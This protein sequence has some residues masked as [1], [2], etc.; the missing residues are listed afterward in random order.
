MDYRMIEMSGMKKREADDGKIY[1]EGYF[2]RFD[3]PYWVFPGW[4]EM[5]RKGAFKNYLESG[6]DVKVLWNHN[7]DIVLGSTAAGT[8]SLTEDDEGLYGTV[9]IN[10]SDTDAMNA[11]ARVLRGDV[12]GCSFGF[13]IKEFDERIDD[14]GIYHTEL[15]EIEPL[16]EVSPCTFPAY[17]T[18]NID[19]R[20]RE[21]MD[22]FRKRKLD[23]WKEEMRKKLKGEEDGA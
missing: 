19:A 21:R 2:A 11:Y 14:D 16:Y 10:R 20:S 4:V 6:K 5:I 23:R 8:A 17:E 15:I 7:P 13:D 9:E 1:L 18:T 22:S 12:S 3:E